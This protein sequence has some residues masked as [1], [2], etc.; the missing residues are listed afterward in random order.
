MK[1]P[2]L[3]RF[4]AAGVFAV[5]LVL[6][7]LTVAPTTSF[8]DSGEFIA[9][10]HGLQVSHPPGAPFYMLVGRF[11]SMV[12]APLLAPFVG[13]AS[14]AVAIN[15]VSVL[16]SALTI[17]LTHL[18]IVRLVRIWQG[19]PEAW[20]PVDRLAAL[21]GGAIG[22]LTFA[23]TDS[24]WFNAVE[25]EV[26]ALSMF[27]TAIVVWLILRWREEKLE[28][29]AALRAQGQ[30][31]FGLKSDRYLVLIAYLFGLA[32]GVHLLNVL[33]L[34]FI[35][36]VVYFVEFDR[37]DVPTKRRV[38]GIVAAGAVAS[39]I[40]LLIYPGIVQ[41]LPSLA[42]AFGSLAVTLLLVAAVVVGAVWTTQKNRMP[43]ANL[44]AVSVMM[45]LIGY[46]TYAVI[47]IR[48]AADP[49]I[50]ENDPET[51]EA[52][53]SYLKR[54]QY[55]ATP[56]L[57]GQTYDD[58][59]GRF[60][61][62][63]QL[64]P[65]RWSQMPQHVQ[66][67]AQ[68]GSDWDFFWRYQVGHMYTRYFLWNFVGKASDEQ[69]APW[70]DGLLR[71]VDTA[72]NAATPSERAGF[73]A[74][75]WLPFLLGLVGLV[76]HFVRDWRRAFAVGVL[77]FITGIGIILYL[78]QT[79]LQPRERDY[80]YV[81]SFFAYSLWVG[82]GATG[83]ISLAA[84][85]LADAGKSAGLRLG[86]GAAIAV[87]LLAAVPGLMIA[88][89]Y[90]DHDRSGRYAAPDFAYNMLQSLAPNAI[91]FTNGDNDTFPLW[92]LQEVEGV[93]RDVRVT[94]LSLLQTPWYIKQ[95]K[96]QWS[97]ES[98]P[99]PMTY[100]SDR[101]VDALAPMQWQPRE[102]SLPVGGLSSETR[103]DLGNPTSL[104]DQIS[105]TVQGR[106]YAQDF[107]VVYV[108]DLVVLSILAAN[109]QAGWERPVYFAT[110][111]ARDSQLDL[112]PYL[113][114]E[115][116]A[117]RVTPI[118]SD[119][120]GGR[121][122]PEVLLD[123]LSK[124]RFTNLDDPDVYFD[125]NVR[126]MM[127]NYRSAVFAPAA[128][129][130]ARQGREAE[131]RALLERLEAEVPFGT[132][133]PDFIA[134][135]QLADAYAALGERERVVALMREAEP[136]AVRELEAATSTRDINLAVQYVQTVQSIYLQNGAFEE[137]AAFSGQIADALGDESY[138]QT[139]DEL[140]RLYERT[141][142]P[143]PDAQ[144]DAAAVPDQG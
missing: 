130:L 93:R 122:V 45:V 144:P 114:A 53:V 44:V 30:H 121:V 39:V 118:E 66:V 131:A 113:Q 98:A 117:L 115:G 6:Y 126:N 49:P 135:Y 41:G 48:S 76:F 134:L 84:R 4:V 31:P 1:G 77:F 27:F 57:K 85:A 105:W 91:L 19:P 133:P 94:N 25:A 14:V 120:P 65:R 75:Y 123:R 55:G 58:A 52:I 60:T 21:G 24:F 103:A 67:Y 12:F 142:P 64:F 99:L 73:N 46:S 56:L 143:A 72:A 136:I 92:Y 36:L 62:E 95:L 37:D 17:L 7:L 108:N 26:Y 42:E 63:E 119:T 101:E 22:A 141:S 40:F 61:R 29:E 109:A 125:E 13:T 8:W 32:I 102:V 111:A 132:I 18:V 69:N 9:I 96:N 80:S 82:I 124:F 28:E 112:G 107:N 16:A 59:M 5:A 23:A 15:L 50:D 2:V 110:T 116:L 83:L 128:T 33:T 3:D 97:R 54:E 11:F 127:D 79:P 78:N 51:T 106:P 129:E 100:T 90:D 140:R 71:N 43:V 70:T 74:Y 38:L 87:L 86:A 138:R 137:A 47:F 104:P 81:A 34:F 20:G 68:Y 88:E 10:A 35:A 89:N 139:T